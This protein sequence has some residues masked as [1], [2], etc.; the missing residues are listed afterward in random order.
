M[1]FWTLHRGFACYALL[2]YSA[3]FI[4]FDFEAAE[5]FIYEPL[6]WFLI[7]FQI[8][9]HS[10]LGMTIGFHRFYSHAAFK[11]SRFVEFLIAYCCAA[12]NQGGMSWWAGN[13]RYHHVHCD[14]DKDPHSPVTHSFLYS[15]LGW[16]YDPA[17]APRSIKLRYPE[18]YWI[19]R[20]C[21]LV[22]WL[23]WG[24]FWLFSDSLAFATLVSLL[25][26]ALSPIGTLFFNSLSHGGKPDE[27][28]CCARKYWQ[29]SAILLGEHDHRD[30][31][32]HPTKAKR[33][34][35]DL[36]YRLVIWPMEKLG[37]IWDVKY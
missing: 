10:G 35:L 9:R 19:D 15:W 23:E 21:F 22:P 33:P 4:Y 6:I 14:D 26:A 13:H 34:G 5:V 2:L 7:I 11:T 31:H 30:H 8:S 16:G 12:S 32:I 36:P 17:H 18:I 28:G 29:L 20:W 27:Q 24:L 25:P 1:V 3:I 37:A